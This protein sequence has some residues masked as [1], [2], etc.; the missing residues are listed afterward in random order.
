MPDWLLQMLSG[1]GSANAA[2]AMDMGGGMAGDL[3]M[4][5]IP[6]PNPQPPNMMSGFDESGVGAP[7]G[8]PGLPAQP[9]AVPSPTPN[10][11]PA[12]T[13]PVQ[14]VSLGASLEPGAPAG[15]PMDVRSINQKRMDGNTSAPVQQAM[16]KQDMA[17]RIQAALKGVQ[18]PPK[19]DVVKPTT[20]H[21]PPA[22]RQIQGGDLMALIQS[23]ST[24]RQPMAR[25]TT[26]GGA[27]GIGRY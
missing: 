9:G 21:G 25:P 11:A 17:Q 22:P 26:L 20:P 7:M 12:V 18:A 8:A 19:P 16:A 14:P 6:A 1:V 10:I 4:A 27:L 2:P 24:P 3:G 13:P 15:T 5:S 23:L